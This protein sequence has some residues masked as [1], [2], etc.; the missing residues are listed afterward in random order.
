M[1]EIPKISG[2]I[3]EGIPRDIPDEIPNAISKETIVEISEGI[4]QAILGGTFRGIFAGFIFFYKI[5]PCKD[6]SGNSFLKFLNKSLTCQSLKKSQKKFQKESLED[7]LKKIPD[8]IVELID[9]PLL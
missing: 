5:Y 2:G 4:F 7:L 1:E 8:G 3:F 6:F 9:L